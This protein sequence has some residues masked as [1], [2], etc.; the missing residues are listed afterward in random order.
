MAIIMCSPVRKQRIQ[1][2]DV[3]VHTQVNTRLHSVSQIH[4]RSRMNFNFCAGPE[5][6]EKQAVYFCSEILYIFVMLCLKFWN[7]DANEN[8]AHVHVGRK[9]GKKASL[10]LCKIWLEPEVEVADQGDLT[11]AQ[12]KQVL[13]LAKTHREQLMK[14][15][16]TF[17]KGEKVRIIK[18]RKQ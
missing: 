13:E 4:V 15:W 8:R 12:V 7:T 6:I 10:K 11:D 3:F 16:G 9:V 17:K 2:P 18:I 5:H 1:S 14:Q